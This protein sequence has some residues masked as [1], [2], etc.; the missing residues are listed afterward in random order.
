[1]NTINPTPHFQQYRCNNGEILLYSGEP[2]IAMLEE[3]EAGPGDV[4][5]SSLDQG[6]CS[7]FP[8][9]VYYATAIWWYL[10]D[11]KDVE[12]C[13]SWRVPSSHMVVRERVWDASAGLDYRFESAVMQDL[14]FGYRMLWHKRV[15]PM[16]V[17]GLFSPD[18]TLDPVYQDWERYLFYNKHFKVSHALFMFVNKI[19]SGSSLI[20]ELKAVQIARIKANESNTVNESSHDI[21]S[22]GEVSARRVSV[23]L[24]TMRRQAYA[25]ALLEDYARQSLKPHEVIVVDQ[26]PEEERDPEAYLNLPEGI[27]VKIIWQ[28]TPGS[29]RARNVALSLVSGEYVVFADDDTRILPNFLG[30]HVAFLESTR[31][32]ACNGLDVRADHHMQTP[33]DLQR[34]LAETEYCSTYVGVSGSFSNA[35]ACVRTG[36]LRKVQGNDLNYE[37]GYGEDSDYGLSLAKSGAVVLLNPY[38]SIL[39]LK[40]PMGGYRWWGL[41]TAKRRKSVELPW[42][43][44]HAIGWIHPRPSPT[45]MYGL[46][47]HYEDN[48]IV[49]WEWKYLLQTVVQGP[50]YLMFI[51]LLALPYRILQLRK[52]KYFARLLLQRGPV[53]D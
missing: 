49:Q 6:Y 30:N 9:V 43:L 42:Q 34:K 47:K 25:R 44:N 21:P 16:Y 33:S 17:R 13:I 50:V 23:V 3:L 2:D 15:V 35:N 36:W 46:M 27:N 5:H 19:L 14:D 48:A 7:A 52:A 29:C 4:W 10:H 39:H 22:V 37:G 24:P 11:F 28:H 53:F 51:R 41:Q 32:D 31:A 18:V 45:V 1:M 26:T 40:P 8:D 20:R 12:R 38:A